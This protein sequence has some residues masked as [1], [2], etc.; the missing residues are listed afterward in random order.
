[1][2]VNRALLHVPSELADLLSWR[3][4]YLIFHCTRLS[5]QPTRWQIF[6]T[7]PPLRLLRNR[8]P[9]TCHEAQARALRFPLLP[10]RGT[11]EAALYCEQER[12][13]G[14]PSPILSRPRVSRAQKIIRLHPLR[15]SA[16]GRRSG[17]PLLPLFKELL[18]PR[19]NLIQPLSQVCLK[20]IGL[21]LH[22][23]TLGFELVLEQHQLGE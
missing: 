22:H 14:A 3:A 15:C 4:A 19:L 13:L 11:S 12:H 7:R 20:N 16:R 18:H 9:G 8:F 5:P 2:C 17:Y 6:F 23:V 10:F 21:G 1:M